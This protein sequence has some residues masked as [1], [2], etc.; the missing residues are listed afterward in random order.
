MKKTTKHIL[1]FAVLTIVFSLPLIT[2]A[3]FIPDREIGSTG[4][5]DT[6]VYTIITSV[7]NWL[8]MLI[9]ILAV[10]GFVISGIM[11]VTAGGSERGETAQKWLTYSII[12]IIVA[13]LGYI[14]INVISSFLVDGGIPN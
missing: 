9:T 6:S 14:V 2:G 12:G 10:I 5:A 11:Y 8:L 1:S 3:Q 4:L 13:L 7:L